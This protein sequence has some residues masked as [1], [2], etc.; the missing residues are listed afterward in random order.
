MTTATNSPARTKV[1][2]RAVHTRTLW[3]K[4]HNHTS[5]EKAIYGVDGAAGLFTRRVRIDYEKHG[6][7]RYVL[8]WLDG[9]T[10]GYAIKPDLSEENGLRVVSVSMNE[11]LA[12]ERNGQ[13]SDAELECHF[14]A[15]L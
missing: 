14:Q 4:V 6:E 7:P 8:A 1:F 3:R 12:Y 2:Y 9:A 15:T 13:V 11:L 10:T 5:L